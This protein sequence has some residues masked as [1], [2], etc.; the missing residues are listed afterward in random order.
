[1]GEMLTAEG[2]LARLGDHREKFQDRQVDVLVATV[3]ANPI[4]VAVTARLLVREEGTVVLV[5]TAGVARYAEKLQ[6]LLRRDGFT[7]QTKDTSAEEPTV[8]VQ[9]VRDAVTELQLA[10]DTVLG[11]NYTGGTKGMAVFGLQGMM[12]VRNEFRLVYLD[13]RALAIRTHWATQQGLVREEPVFVGDAPALSIEEMIDLH[14]WERVNPAPLAKPDAP[15][16]GDEGR[17]F[18]SRIQ[19]ELGGCGITWSQPPLRSYH[20]EFP[21]SDLAP[22]IA[23]PRCEVDVIGTTGYVLHYVTAT[24]QDRDQCR[25]KLM[26]GLLRARQIGGDEA[27][28]TLVCKEKDPQRDTLRRL[29]ASLTQN[30][31]GVRVYGESDLANL[32]KRYAQHWEQEVAKR[33]ERLKGG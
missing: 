1:M 22:D 26:E 9:A 13:P 25:L 10:G 16:S 31:G 27:R 24:I 15:P 23:R 21:M 4:P 20:V 28:L 7:V 30:P 19:Q 17:R 3:G 12:A 14:G 32:G 5:H 11:C 6:C 29:A 2:A 8:I 18:E 33:K